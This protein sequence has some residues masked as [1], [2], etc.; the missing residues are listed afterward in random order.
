MKKLLSL[1]L[2]L[3]MALSL[4]ACGGEKPVEKP[5]ED[6]VDEVEEQQTVFDFGAYAVEFKEAALV[7][8]DHGFDCV[9]LTLAYTN[10]DPEETGR[11]GENIQCKAFQNGEELSPGSLSEYQKDEP[12]YVRDGAIVDFHV[13][14]I[15]QLQ[16]NR[17]YYDMSEIEVVL[18][19][20]NSD[21]S[22]SFTVDPSAL[23]ASGTEA[24]TVPGGTE[25]FGDFASILVPENFTL[26]RSSQDENNPHFVS[27]AHSDWI[28]FNFRNYT[29]EEDM[30]DE[31]EYLKENYTDGQ[32]DVSTNYGGI[33]WTAF[34]CDD[35]SG[36]CKFYAST[37]IGDNY[38][39]VSSAGFAF[40]DDITKSV[41]GSVIMADGTGSTTGASIL[42]GV[43]R[44]DTEV[45]GGYHGSLDWLDYWT[46]DWYGWWMM[47]DGTGLY[48]QWNDGTG[49]GVYDACARIEAYENM[50]GYME[51]WDNSGSDCD[52]VASI[53]VCFANPDDT[54][55]GV[56]GCIGGKFIG[57]ALEEGAWYINPD[58]FIYENIIDFEGDYEDE[59]GTFYYRVLLRPWG[60][61]WDDMDES[62]YPEQYYY[63]WYLPLVKAGAAM[64]DSIG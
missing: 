39:L 55:F 38:L 16:D 46:G 64:P 53:D 1:L 36:G 26:Q 24:A 45:G 34:Q 31:Y 40:D 7:E 59:D 52:P 60:I 4:A 18:Q 56:M 6:P 15:L 41:L 20:K 48:A 47:T 42:T 35:G 5:A 22:Y 62:L 9:M 3:T 23:D 29:Y 27:V 28:Y 2:A 49:E 50:T 32:I 30:Q 61:E 21:L 33:D 37:V 57:V 13:G 51:L 25:S 63:D 19:D 44:T 43:D 14:Y 54:E 17:V 11:L 8:A 58:E 10:I 12:Y